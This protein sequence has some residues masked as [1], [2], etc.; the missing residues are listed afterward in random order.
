MNEFSVLENKKLDSKTSKLQ[1]SA[2]KRR[3]NIYAMHFS[4][5][6]IYLNLLEFQR[7][8]CKIVSVFWFLMRKNC[9]Q[10]FVYE[11]INIWI[12]YW[13]IPQL[14]SVSSF[15]MNSKGSVPSCISF[16]RFPTTFSSFLKHDKW[17]RTNGNI[18]WVHDYIGNLFLL[19][20]TNYLLKKKKLVLCW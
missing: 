15:T 16:G 5:N 2:G 3:W 14:K 12:S 8:K 20:I 9:F 11:L 17:K 19:H 18:F 1:F 6:E 4:Q 10:Q 13:K 7:T